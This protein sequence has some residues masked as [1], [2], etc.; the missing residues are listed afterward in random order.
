MTAFRTRLRNRESLIGPLLT[1]GSPEVAEVFALL[2]YDWLWIDLEHTSLSLERAQMLIQATAGRAGTVIRVPWNDPVH[3]KHA[4]DLGCDGVIV[5]QVKTVG[6]A[7][8]AIAASKYPPAGVRSVGIARA[9]Q[10]GLTLQDCVLKANDRV[11]VILQI[12]HVDALPN[13]SDILQVPGLDAILV[14]PYDLSA[15]MGMPGQISHPDVS[16]AIDTIAAACKKHNVAWGAFAPN[17]ESAKAHIARG[18]TLIA[19]GTDT[20]HLWTAARSALA[21]LKQITRR[22]ATS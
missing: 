22:D 8:K 5:P 11:S 4:L 7:V 16:A 14:G 9:Q 18:A 12:E 19:L 3:I 6:E 10:Y 1:L 17:V 21:E 2:G 15:S 13:V 20:I